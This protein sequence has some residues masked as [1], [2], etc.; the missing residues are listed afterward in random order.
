MGSHLKP[1]NTEL[2]E[3][4]KILNLTSEIRKKK[5]RGVGSETSSINNA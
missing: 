2:N 4:L 3:C 5:Q 1:P